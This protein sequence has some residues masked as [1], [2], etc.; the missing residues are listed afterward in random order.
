MFTSDR[1]KLPYRKQQTRTTRLLRTDNVTTNSLSATVMSVIDPIDLGMSH[2]SY[3]YNRHVEYS[4]EE[5]ADD[6]RTNSEVIPIMI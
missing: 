1:H 2:V 5:P 6:L 4:C 3:K